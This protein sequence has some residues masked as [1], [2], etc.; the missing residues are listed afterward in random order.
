MSWCSA[1]SGSI[2]LI[3]TVCMN[4]QE[5]MRRG[6]NPRRENSHKNRPRASREDLC[7]DGMHSETKEQ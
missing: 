4:I 6:E 2:L 5:D 3:I 7:A 1:T